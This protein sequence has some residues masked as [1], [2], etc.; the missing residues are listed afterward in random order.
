MIVTGNVTLWVQNSLAVSGSGYI[1]IAPGASLTLYVGGT[2]SISGGG[3]VNGTGL[4][5]NFS[6]YGLPSNKTLNY[7]GAANFVGTINA[8]RADFAL[9]GGASVYGAIICNTFNLSGGS[10]VHYDQS[11]RG[12]GIFLITSWVEK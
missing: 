5:Q 1:Y 8:P 2:A 7:S 12:G 11:V 3:V 9:S 6:Y 10:S 4:P